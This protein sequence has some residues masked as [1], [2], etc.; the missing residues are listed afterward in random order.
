MDEDTI[1]KEIAAIRRM[2]EETL[3]R[4]IACIRNTKLLNMSDLIQVLQ[5]LEYDK[6]YER[7][8]V[9]EEKLKEKE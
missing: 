4:E 1:D 8:A 9:L 6:L 2:N 5:V 3:E 7:V